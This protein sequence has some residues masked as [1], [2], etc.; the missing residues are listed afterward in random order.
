MTEA[1]A[2]FKLLH[3]IIAE[4]MLCAGRAANLVH[5]LLQCSSLPGDLAEFGCHTGRTAAMMAF[6][7]SKPI[8]LY[9]SFAGLPERKPQDEGSLPHFKRGALAVSPSTLLN[10]FALYRLREPIVYEGWFSQIPTNKLP[11]RICFAHLDGDLYDSLR[12]SLRLV[13]PR[14]VPGGACLIDDYGWAGTAGVKIAVDEYLRDKPDRIVPLQ[15][16][17]PEG[18]Q[19]VIVKI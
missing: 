12:D 16:G 17:N 6:T 7:V 1:L 14:L 11:E 10:Y 3:T 2:Y 8:W 18:F 19:A 5:Y 15:T 9:D 13:Y 4:G